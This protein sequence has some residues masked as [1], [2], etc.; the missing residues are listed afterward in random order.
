MRPTMRA[1]LFLLRHPWAYWVAVAITL[2]TGVSGVGAR[3]TAIDDERCAW[4]ETRT[5]LIADANGEV[6]EI[7]AVSRREVPIGLAPVTAI[8]ADVAV[9]R[10]QQAVTAGEIIVDIDVTDTRGPAALAR[11]GHV[12]L[13]LHDPF[14]LDIELGTAVRVYAD[15]RTIADEAVVGDVFS[16]VVMVAVDKADAAVVTDAGWLRSASLGFPAGH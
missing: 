1:R 9:G 11:P 7:P 10:L 4:G 14:G 13:A 3:L 16:G 15:G 8:D 12:V 5:V 6:G 2:V